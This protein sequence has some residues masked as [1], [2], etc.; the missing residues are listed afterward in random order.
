MSLEPLRKQPSEELNY[1]IDFSADV[2]DG[3]TLTLISCT[4]A[5]L[6]TGKDSSATVLATSPAPAVVEQT[7]TFRMKGGLDR[8]HHKIT[9]KVS[10]SAGEKL[11]ADLDMFILEE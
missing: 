10:T 4:A 1:A 11:E 7:V 9:V 3:V 5:N 8:E 6:T 2:A